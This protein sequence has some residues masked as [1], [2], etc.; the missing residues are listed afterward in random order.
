MA[1]LFV[2]L[3]LRRLPADGVRELLLPL[4]FVLFQRIGL[5]PIVACCCCS[6]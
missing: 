2:L 1:L 4:L 3:L 6:C 5:L